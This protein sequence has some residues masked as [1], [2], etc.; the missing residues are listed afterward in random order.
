[1]QDTKKAFYFSDR[2]DEFIIF[3]II[4]VSYNQGE[5]YK[6][7]VGYKEVTQRSDSREIC[8]DNVVM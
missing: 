6:S 5:S 3:V 8:E 4:I 7:C 2:S 1:M